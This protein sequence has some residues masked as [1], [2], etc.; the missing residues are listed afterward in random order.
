MKPIKLIISAFGPYAEKTEIDFERLGDHGLYLITGDT[1]SGKTTIFDA[2][3]FALYGEASGDVRETGMFRSQY[4]KPGVPTYVN[5]TFS[6]RGS[7]YQIIR[8]PEYMRPKE[9]GEGLTLQKADGE[10]RFFDGKAPITKFTEVTRAVEKLIGL[11]YRQFTQIAMIA[12]G[13]FQKLLLAGTAQ[14]S[15]IFRQIFHTGLYQDMQNRL[16][17]AAKERWAEYEEMRKSICQH[18][19]GVAYGN[20][21][22]LGLQS[23]S[24]ELDAMK[25]T[26]FK[27]TVGRGLEILKELLE[28]QQEHLE[29]LDGALRILDQNIQRE[30]QL[31]GES[32]QNR[33]LK[34]ELERKQEEYKASTILMEDARK[35]WEESKIWAEECGELAEQIRKAGEKLEKYSQLEESMELWKKKTSSI[36]VREQEYQKKERRITELKQ[37]IQ[38]AKVQLE[39]L[40]TAGEEKERLTHQLKETE[41]CRKKLE[42][43]EAAGKKIEEEIK[44]QEARYH[45]LETEKSRQGHRLALH[46]SQW[47]QIKDA[48]LKL[49]DRQRVQSRLE[50]DKNRIQEVIKH[51][52][53]RQLLEEQM[54]NIQQ[55]YLEETEERS[56]LRQ[57]YQQLEQMFLDAQAGMLA[58]HLKMGEMCPV[59][60]SLHHPSPAHLPAKV[61]KKEELDRKKEELSAI[62]NQVQQSSADIRHVREQIET[63]LETIRTVGRQVLESL[64]AVRQSGR[65]CKPDLV[66][67]PERI[68]EL[69][70]VCEPD[71]TDKPGEILRLLNSVLSDFNEKEERLIQEIESLKQQENQKTELEP[72][73]AKEQEA[74]Q[75][76]DTQIQEISVTLAA[77]RGQ[78]Q[79]RKRQWQQTAG[80]IMECLGMEPRAKLEPGLERN[81]ESELEQGDSFTILTTAVMEELSNTINRLNGFLSQNQE[82]ILRKQELERE[83]PCKEQQIQ[84]LQ[85]EMVQLSIEKTRLQAETEG[86]NTQIEQMK[87]AMGTGDKAAIEYQMFQDKERKQQLESQCAVAETAYQDCQKQSTILHSAIETLQSQ[88]KDSSQWKEE[89]IETRKKQW[90]DQKNEIS[91]E[92]ADQY[93]AIKN[94]REIYHAVCE[95]QDTMTS[96]ERE[97]IWIKALS[98]TANGTLA[99]KQKIELE[100]YVQMAYFDRILRRANLRLMTMSSGQYELKRQEN[101][102]NKK[103]KAG[104]ELNV[105]DHYNGTERS[106]KTLSG[107]ESFQ[108]SLS[109]AL[110]L[111]DEIQ[112]YAGG[113]RLDTMFVDEGF[114]SLDEE[115]LNQAIQALNSLTGN[116]RM[117][118]IISHVAELKDRIEKKI[119]VTKNR[120]GGQIGSHVKIVG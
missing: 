100:T 43:T 35:G 96:A 108:A 9:R 111:S 16:K 21:R 12:Q 63:E 97:L 39:Q 29:S 47:E 45:R 30:D 38:N 64:D 74:I 13:D 65:V 34:E 57:E 32:R 11:D 24:D 75:G 1:G 19:D 93:A 98:D 87:T 79:E 40:K 60:G 52:K 80:P 10:L 106:V 119:I 89:E 27:G 92:R 91:Q 44:D 51:G 73:L 58:S 2:L 107:G 90:A 61:P 82:K 77:A 69:N 115:S 49:A 112:S 56:R 23:L 70:Q 53:T 20:N 31:L 109:L 26:E 86:L 102:E 113:I 116:S 25:R 4:A 103:E 15:E 66:C 48:E 46:Q 14:R 101:G 41:E 99:G 94:N 84:N 68:M 42:E 7:Q 22:D 18:M 5:L 110:G 120:N 85:Q 81:P 76:I 78:A 54:S 17:E 33:Q 36:T 28:K 6:Y 50:Q 55:R 37:N 95:K 71:E 83:V 118:G 59:C 105:I 72:I 114:G 8:N 104:L 3:T 67:E 117:V 62:E 88:I